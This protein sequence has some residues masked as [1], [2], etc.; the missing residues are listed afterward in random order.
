MALTSQ[1]IRQKFLDYFEDKEH[2]ILSSAPLVPKDDPTLLWVNAGMVPFKPYFDGRATPPNSRVATSQKCIRTND[3]ENVGQTDRHH[4]FFE[5]LGNFSFGDYFKEEAITWAY[6]FLTEEMGLEKDKLWISTYEED[7]RAYEIWSEEIGIPED[8]IVLMGKDENFWQI[9]TGPCGPCSEIHYDLGPEFGCSDD[10]QFGCDC[11]RYREV[12]NLVFTQYDYTEAG[13]Y[14]PLPNKNIDTGMGLERLASIIQ[15]VDSNFETDLFMPLIEFISEHSEFDY[16]DSEEIKAAFR[17]IADHIRSVTFAIGDGILPSN[18]GRGYIIRRILRRA[19]RYA[20]KLELEMPFLYRIVP[21]VVEIMGTEYSEIVEKE[22]QIKKV[23]KSEEIK[24]QETLNQGMEILEELMDDLA[25]EDKAVIPGDEVFTL[26]DTYGFPQE[27]TKELA[28]ER[29]YRIDEEGFEAAMEEQRSRARAAREDHDL[30]RDKIKL[31]KEIRDEIAKPEFVG[32]TTGECQSEV[33]KI[34][35]DGR[36]VDSLSAG[37]TGEVILDQTPFYAESGGQI[38]DQGVLLADNLIAKVKDT[39]EETELITHHIEVEEGQLEVG[40]QVKAQIESEYRKDIRRNHSATHLL[41]KSLR[42]VLGEHVEQSGSLV[43]ADRLRFDFTHFEAPGEEEL[44]EVEQLVNQQIMDN[45]PV[46]ALEMSRDKAEEMGAEALFE[47]KYGSKVRV[48][49]MGDYSLEL[50]GG[51]HV[52]ATGEINLFKIVSESGVAAG[53]RRIEAV[54][55]KQALTYVNQQEELLNEVA[56]KLKTDP[57]NL[58]TRVDKMQSEVK[59]LEKEVTKFKDKLADSQA[60]ELTADLEEINGVNVLLEQVDDLDA[61]GLRSMGDN[62]KEELDSG[63]ALL[64]SNL[65]EKVLFVSVVTED[66]VEQGYNAGDLIGQVAQVAGG[67]GGGRPDMAQA[68]GSQPEKLDA[69]FEK[70]REIIAAE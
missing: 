13:E 6:E 17:V 61:D 45:L 36:S 48:I 5:M 68:G 39:Q 37:K 2:L 57:D 15:R 46:E 31:F 20:H 33:V 12:W 64:A 56:D 43:A 32:Y 59:E 66:L 8:R 4:T 3:I 14:Q 62:L 40:S 21:E 24:F 23:I 27:L 55:G 18:E 28:Q 30:E 29:G 58:L 41:H 25:A 38:G 67:G 49:K 19:V 34:I 9:G 44:A 50:C 60:D 47:E 52:D 63:I 35:A 70:A 69:A 53:V 26:Y 16:E 1:Q 51:T 11:D 54:T 7:E 65:G 22:E 10:C 42:D